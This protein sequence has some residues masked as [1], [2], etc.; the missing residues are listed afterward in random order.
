MSLFTEIEK[1][2]DRAFRSW[3]Q[4]AFG[5]ERAN[6]LVIYHR[7]ILEEIMGKVQV[8]ARGQRVFPFAHVLI[9]IVGDTERRREVLRAAF[10]DRLPSDIQ[11][12]LRAIRCEIPQGF[13]AIVEVVESGIQT[14]ELEYS[15]K[16]PKPSPPAAPPARLVVVKGKAE[17][18]EYALDKPRINVGRLPELT[19]A[20]QRVVR[21]NDIVFEEGAD[22][23]SGTVSRKHAHIVMEDG[24][25]RICDDRSEFGTS[26]FRDGRPIELVKGGRRGEKLRPGDEIYFGRACM[27]FEQ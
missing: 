24:E 26:I 13:T 14:I 3:T 7:A 10:G 5:A 18:A 2:I 11:S 27:R 20:S 16:P 19:D 17:R 15:V 6:D 23:V 4:R 21:R 1:T 22:E 25:Y 8:L 12:A 9:R